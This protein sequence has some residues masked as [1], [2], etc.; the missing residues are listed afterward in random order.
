MYNRTASYYIKK[1]FF[2]NSS[3]NEKLSEVIL[4]NVKRSFLD[5][6]TKEKHSV[7]ILLNAKFKY[8]VGN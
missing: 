2:M 4:L 1:E 7:V 6:S 8:F 5:G 3:T